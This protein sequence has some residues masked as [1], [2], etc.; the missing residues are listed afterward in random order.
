MVLTL[1]ASSTTPLHTF[2]ALRHTA[3]P[4]APHGFYRLQ[5]PI[6]LA[7][8]KSRGPSIVH[9]SLQRMHTI[10]S[11]CGSRLPNRRNGQVEEV[12]RVATQVAAV[13]GHVVE[14]GRRFLG[15]A[16]LDGLEVGPGSVDVEL[17][18]LID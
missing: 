14:R 12:P 15:L 6:R 7:Q 18:A 11:S 16:R 3:R 4:Q 2:S 13:G 5:S 10:T 1:P 17:H 9:A 8:G